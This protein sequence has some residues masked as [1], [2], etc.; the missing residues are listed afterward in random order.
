MDEVYGTYDKYGTYDIYGTYPND[1]SRQQT[2]QT[3]T[4][5]TTA[6]TAISRHFPSISRHFSSFA[7]PQGGI[8]L[9]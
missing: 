7:Q 2:R 9:R 6:P 8:T 5:L 4:L 3:R 1:D